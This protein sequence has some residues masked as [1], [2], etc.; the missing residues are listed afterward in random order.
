M[1]YRLIEMGCYGLGVSRLLAAVIEY[2]CRTPQDKHTL[3]WPLPIAPF[4]I[5]VA[6]M[7]NV[8]VCVCVCV[9][10]LLEVG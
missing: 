1:Y 2:G 7:T 9:C 6:P 4:P 10:A 5:C 3:V 8:C